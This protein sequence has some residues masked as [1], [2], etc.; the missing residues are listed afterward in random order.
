MSLTW[1]KK[2]K[3]RFF[4]RHYGALLH[5]V[6]R[7]MAWLCGALP[8]ITNTRGLSMCVPTFS[9]VGK[10]VTR[11]SLWRFLWAPKN[12]RK[13]PKK[14]KRQ[15]HLQVTIDFFPPTWKW[16]STVRTTV[17]GIAIGSVRIKSD[18]SSSTSAAAA[19][20]QL[21]LLCW[22]N[23]FGALD[24]TNSVSPIGRLIKGG[25]KYTDYFLNVFFV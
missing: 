9:T 23:F 24:R 10:T 1:H 18:F 19:A 7:E 16:K 22:R 20:A 3:K 6:V 4:C 2:A 15:F 11:E 25:G 14:G 5:E 17:Q 12:E 21:L 8:S 13:R